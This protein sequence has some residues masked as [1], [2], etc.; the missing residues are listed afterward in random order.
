MNIVEVKLKQLFAN[1]FL[2]TILVCMSFYI[3]FLLIQTSIT[4]LYLHLLSSFFFFIVLCVLYYFRDNINPDKVFLVIIASLM[5]ILP[6]GFIQMGLLSENIIIAP[7]VPILLRMIF[8]I[9]GGKI[10]LIYLFIVLGFFSVMFCTNI[11]SIDL[12]VSKFVTSSNAWIYDISII[13]LI[14]ILF[15][16]V[17]TPAELT[18]MEKQAW[19]KAI[20][21]GVHD[22]IFI[23]DVH[24]GRIIECNQRAIEV[25]GYSREE[26]LEAPVGFLSA[27]LPP[28]TSSL[29]TEK[30]Q[31]VIKEG[32]SNFCWHLKRKDETLLWVE[33]D[34]RRIRIG[35]L[36]VIITNLR[37][38]SLR[39]K[40]EEQL[41]Q[42]KK[43]E[44]VGRLA[45]GIAHDF[46]NLLS[47]IIG[48]SD[49]M[50]KSDTTDSNHRD[51]LEMILKAGGRARDLT[52]Q[53]LAF[54]RKQILLLKPLD[55][56][57]ILK[58]IEQILR[59]TIREDIHI[60]MTIQPDAGIVRADA[61]QIE[62]IL[63]NL[64]LNAQDAMPKGG[65]LNFK[66]SREMF[67]PTNPDESNDIPPA[68]H[69]MLEITDSGH[70]MSQDVLQHLFEPF[71]TTKEKGKGT[72]L[73]LSM[74][75]G[76]VKQHNGHILAESTLNSGTTFKIYLPVTTD[77][78]ENI[79]EPQ[80]SV[81]AIGGSETI[82][83][84]E[85]DEIVRNMIHLILTKQGYKVLSAGNG[86]KCLELLKN[87]QDKI[88]MLLTDIIMPAMNGKELY[89]RL[90][91]RF[92]TLKVLFISGYDQ[93]VITRQGILDCHLHYLQKPFT[94]DSLCAKI[95]ET[96]ESV[97]NMPLKV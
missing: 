19:L 68:P 47:P 14:S 4:G 31:Q 17:Y 42:A 88:D 6:V 11:L 96:I 56:E 61:G 39:K 24:S 76:I 52:S 58:E 44:S 77:N 94:S 79:S 3:V 16:I 37:D 70:G 25:F 13:F 46:N 64:A 66:L 63:M 43:M 89:E 73:G 82:M 57:K 60:K 12:D 23:R 40:L 21:N 15:F 28:Y 67:Q 51:M 45:G 95:R 33:G 18:I 29:F 48:F 71:F 74:V 54:S 92:S 1:R 41:L 9:R 49:L 35:E 5:L 34:M 20:F 91:M 81:S 38:M 75:Y 36:D 83:V 30:F 27:E 72:G 80:V 93:N 85:D 84:V 59:H 10:G 7:M 90:S 8:G 62:Q 22:A 69:V 87:S 65:T 2:E 97:C 86:P 78:I 32:Y 55:L 50:L 53:L 26:I